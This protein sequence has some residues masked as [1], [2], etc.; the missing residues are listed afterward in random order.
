MSRP[1][2][3]LRRLSVP[4]LALALALTTL[5]VLLVLGTP[6][7]AHA[8][9]VSFTGGTVSWGVKAS[10]RRYIGRGSQAGGGATIDGWDGNTPTGFTFPVESG[11]F[12]PATSTTVLDLAGFVHFQQYYEFVEPGKY[13][14]DTKYSDLTLTIGPDV[15]EIR[16]THTGYLRDDPGGDLHEDV[17][18]VLASFDVAGAETSFAPDRSTWTG[19]PTVAGAGFAIYAEG[20]AVDPVGIDYPGPGGVPDLAERF[21]QPGVP[22]LTPS[23][24]WSTG[25]T[26]AGGG[27]TGRTLQVSSR[28]DVVYAVQV[29]PQT[30]HHLVV[31]ALDATTLAPVGTP[32]QHPLAATG[33][34]QRFVRTAVDPATD[35]LFYLTGRDGAG[36]N[37]VTAHALT[38]DRVSE[39]FGHTTVGAVV[40]A[41]T[42]AV[43]GLAWNA[44]DQELAVVAAAG[45][46]TSAASPPRLLRF[47]RD[48]EAWTVTDTPFSLG[49]TD[50]F[51]GGQACSCGAVVSTA[52]AGPANL[53]VLGDGSYLLATGTA[54]LSSG[55]PR[56]YVPAQRLDVGLGDTLAVTSVPGTEAV[57][58]ASGASYGR[59]L[60]APGPGGSVYLH[61][62]GQS[63]DDVQRVDLVDGVA[64]AGGFLRGPDALPPYDLSLLGASVAYDAGRDLLWALDMAVAGGTALKLIDATGVV[65]GYPVP[66]LPLSSFG[67]PSVVVGVDGSLY[68]PVREADNGPFSFERLAFDGI[69]PAVTEQ[70]ADVE[71]AL[72]PDEAS[73][74]VDFTTAVAEEPGGDLQWQVRPPGASRFADVAGATSP[75]LRVPASPET[76][77]RTYRAVASNAAGRVVSDEAVL[78]VTYAPRLT[79]QP[80]DVRVTEGSGAL[81]TAAA[82][83]NPTVSSLTW[84]RRVGGFWEDVTPGD[85][86]AVDTVD[87]LSSLRIGRTEADQSGA[88]F[89]LKA[90]S[91]AGTT[92][93]RTAVVTVE[94]EV[95]VPP[96]GLDL[97]GAVLDWTGSEELQSAPPFGGNNYFSAGAS[98]GDQASYRAVEGDVAVLQVAADGAEA[99]ATWATRADH[100]AG[101]G[102]QLVRLSG[103]EAHLAADGSATVVWDGSWS[104]NF[105]GGLVPF[106]ISDPV[107]VVG[108]D[109]TGTLV[110]DLSGYASS[111]EDPEAK[112]PMTPVPDV[113][114]ATFA[115]VE[116]D[117]AG[118][119]EVTP[120]YDGVEVDVPAGHTAQDR[121]SAGW[122]AWPQEFVD[123]H[124]VTG[125]SSYWYSS[126][127]A[128]DPKKRPTPFSLDLGD[129]T[130]AEPEPEPAADVASTTTVRLSTPSASYGAPVSATVD[131]AAPGTTPG[132]V[133][134]VRVGDQVVT[135]T[136]AAGRATVALPAGLRPGTVAV[137]ASYAGRPGVAG[138]EGRAALRVA[139]A[140]PRVRLVLPRTATAATRAR[141]RLRVHVPR[142]PRVRPTGQVVI[143]EG[144]RVVA[145]ATLTAQAGGRLTVRLPRLTPGRH[146]LRAT[147][148][149]SELFRSGTSP[150]RTVVVR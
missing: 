20:A 137:T 139:R 4:L 70:P 10:W 13:A 87:G 56:P 8:A 116:V 127:G 68:V 109:G 81:L 78:T 140:V 36:G 105:Y 58:P 45:A 82:I 54:T 124:L 38:Y 41:S 91:A 126:G 95:V 86:L 149:G 130:A 39:T 22:V 138:S 103:G 49:A 142:L 117:P 46:T 14:L 33:T 123:V 18:V 64:V 57:A 132:G 110:G 100:V 74:S 112:T 79:T 9:P 40:V 47:A 6:A 69:A 32:Y 80:R 42:A 88:R 118:R 147:L 66:D 107:L 94:P 131:V 7:P 28:G 115:G 5:P 25:S 24:R 114:I 111:M 51:P 60:A 104:V 97:D 2:A 34:T 37:G 106:T 30:A 93:S 62:D 150:Y 71:V 121:T 35:T 125:L 145:V 141:A 17:D 29:T 96:E 129:A 53:A 48:G 50:T 144:G 27:A 26:A 136:L 120:E 89:R 90:V 1:T 128:A 92:Y 143:R 63:R 98:A 101:D 21:A 146:H 11:T 3:R 76:D 84:Q 52:A 135:G 75:T 83:G 119:I 31:Q 113:T 19:I 59:T 43:G 148:A 133:V 23:G 67:Q 16:G 77:G 61:G 134:A 12:D 102:H 65:A 122:G 99:P 73:R 108:A 55:T 44:V 72:A 85:E 15:Q